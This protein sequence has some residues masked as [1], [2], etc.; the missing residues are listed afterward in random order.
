MRTLDGFSIF[1]LI[2]LF[3]AALILLIIST[4]RL[5]KN[6]SVKTK[7]K[8]SLTAFSSVFLYF[9]TYGL[10][11]DTADYIYFKTKESLMN[12]FV[13]NIRTYKKI[14]QFSDEYE[15]LNGYP[16]IAK[17]NTNVFIQL[18]NNYPLDSIKNIFNID[19]QHYEIFRQKLKS[20]GYRSFCILEDGTISF[21][22]G[23]MID[24]CYGIAYSE[25]GSKPIEN[26]CGRIIRWKKISD[27]WFAWGTT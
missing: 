1:L 14:T 22:Q 25:T 18:S 20:S 11:L 21:T 12:E 17:N 3:L 10:Q 23:G 24:N 8:Y 16:T 7:I 9:F 27:H 19:N 26:D 5:S 15:N 2:P 6:Q 13:A 4:I